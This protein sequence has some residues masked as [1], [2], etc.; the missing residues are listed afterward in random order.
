MSGLVGSRS[1]V[2][3]IAALLAL[4]ANTFV[5]IW[6]VERVKNND[7]AVNHS[8]R[9][10]MM[11][12]LALSDVK[13][14][15]TGERGFIITGDS[16]YL[17][18]YHFGVEHIDGRLKA[19]KELTRDNPDQQDA[20]QRIEALADKKLHELSSAIWVAEQFGLERA[21]WVV[22]ANMGRQLMDSIREEI[23]AMEDRENELLNQ[24][25]RVA[26]QTYQTSLITSLSGGVLTMAMTGLAFVLVR[27]ELTRRRRTEDSLRETGRK[28]RQHA[29]ELTRTQRHAA[30]TL[31]LL[32]GF[33]VN[34]PIGLAFIS[35]EKRFIRINRMMAEANGNRVA[36]LL[37]VE[38]TSVDTAFFIQASGN[39]EQVLQTR[40]PV[41]DRLITQTDE[42]PANERVWQASYYPIK[43]SDG[44][45]VGIGMIAQDVTE[46]LRNERA[47]RES[48]ARFRALAETMPQIVWMS[49][50]DGHFEYFNQ[51]WYDF[52]GLT[53]EQ[54]RGGGWNLPLH[55]E[56]RE[57]T[58][59]RWRESIATG[60]SF[61]IEYRLRGADGNYR[62][63]LGRAL[64]HS[65]DDQQIVS[66]F[67][68]CTDI[69]D[70]KIQAEV[71]E[72]L[73]QERTRDL[74]AMNTALQ[75]EVETRKTA[76]QRERDA[77]EE[78]RRSN[79]E[80][81]QF[82]YV[83]SHDLQEPLRKIQAFGDRLAQKF[84]AQLGEQGQ[85]YLERITSSASRMRNLINDLLSFSRIATRPRKLVEI[86]LGEVVQGVLSDLEERIRISNGQV[87][88]NA[89]PR[90]EADPMQIQ[91]V[92]LNLINNALKFHRPEAPPRVTISATLVEEPSQQENRPGREMYR[93]EVADNGIGFESKYAERIFQIFQRLH[94][95]SEYEGTGMGL[96]I[97]RKIVERHGGS[98]TATSVPGVGSTF[99][100]MLP[101]RQDGGE[102]SP[103]SVA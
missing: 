63:F 45:P 34:A 93:I 49:R 17:K 20:A 73:V 24:R 88:V 51:R 33:L 81:E 3:W 92:F 101:K 35:N 78:L 48:Q 6:N 53:Y 95:R 59:L 64:P 28:L 100:M 1:A 71:L 42:D 10:L 83:A 61:E 52:T 56:D 60:R 57:R 5:S 2:V 76:E 90:I 69:H 7:E 14:A 26:R 74:S 94:G 98:I 47:V 91:Q 86:D 32:E 15:E 54:S 18:P 39:V 22:S 4:A 41:L 85:Q 65:D 11:L 97:V 75:I 89:L 103:G 16:E 72:D 36:E 13:D 68:T 82:A 27:R 43:D 87:V 46:R 70:R 99:V 44:V 31:A 67:G 37:G 30:D 102:E 9:V 40:R 77:G 23:A 84:D 66:W 50:S 38:L 55:P 29:E 96:A 80:L 19:L 8:R 21:R 79:Q 58:T 12:R 62:W 25:A